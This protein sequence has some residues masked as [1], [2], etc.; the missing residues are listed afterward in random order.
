MPL[1]EW[2][3]RFLLGV[4]DVDKHHKYLVWLINKIYDKHMG[5]ASAANVGLIINELIEYAAYHFEAEE[6]WMKI[7]SYP[8]LAEHKAEHEG[9]S[10]RVISYQKSL[11]AGNAVLLT[12]LL[13]FL[14]EWVNAHILDSDGDYGRFRAANGKK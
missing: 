1:F 8:K 9:F 10:E 13:P 11:N 3:S 7:D 6:R 14:E 5:G 4:P 12:E 2:S